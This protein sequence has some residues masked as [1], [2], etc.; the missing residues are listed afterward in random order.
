MDFSHAHKKQASH[1]TTWPLFPIK[2][3]TAAL[4]QGAGKAPN[5]FD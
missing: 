3:A 1:G 4:Q 2:L 5:I